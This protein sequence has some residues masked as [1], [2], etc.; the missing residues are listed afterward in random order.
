MMKSVPTKYL[1]VWKRTLLEQQGNQDTSS[2]VLWIQTEQ[3]HA[4]IR[5][6]SLRP[7]FSNSENLQDCSAEQLR[8]LSSQQGFTGTTEVNSSTCQWHREF[9]FQPKK[10]SRDIGEMVFDGDD[11]LLET[12]IDTSYFEVWKKA[13]HSH[14]NVSSH[15]V[16]GKDRHGVATSA[17]LLI[18][19]NHFAY[20]RPRNVDLPNASCL[21]VVL[22]KYYQSMNKLLDWLDFEI[23]FGEKIDDMTGIIY[24]ST[25]LFVKESNCL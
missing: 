17:K 10:D 15:D 23:S 1:G 16:I 13:K 11:T 5:I 25:Y 19:G 21:Q 24:H 6:P 12:G 22:E 20:V 18:A 4:D 9:D 3:Q 7:D 2:L 8:W 14:L